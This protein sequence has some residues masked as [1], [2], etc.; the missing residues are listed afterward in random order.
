M[1]QVQCGGLEGK[2]HLV[3]AQKMLVAGENEQFCPASDCRYGWAGSWGQTSHHLHWDRGAIAVALN[4]F[5]AQLQGSS[6]GQTHRQHS[7]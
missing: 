7:A 3:A 1:L 2:R 6:W 4:S 5:C